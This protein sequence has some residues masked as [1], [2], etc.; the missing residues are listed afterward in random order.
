MQDGAFRT[1]TLGN[2]RSS[3][4]SKAAAAHLLLNATAAA[5]TANHV[6]YGSIA[7]ALGSAGQ[8]TYA[9][10]NGELESLAEQYAAKVSISTSK[11]SFFLFPR[12]WGDDYDYSL[13]SNDC[14]C[15]H[16]KYYSDNNGF[17]IKRP[18]ITIN[19][20]LV[21]FYRFIIKVIRFGFGKLVQSV[22]ASLSHFFYS[23]HGGFCVL[24]YT[25]FRKSLIIFCLKLKNSLKYIHLQGVSPIN[26]AW[27]AWDGVGMAAN[28]NAV[29]AKL[30]SVGISSMRPDGGLEIMQ[31]ILAARPVVA[32]TTLLVADI[33]WN[34]LL[35]NGRDH[36][37][38]YADLVVAKA[39]AAV[40]PIRR[41]TVVQQDYTAIVHSTLEHVLGHTV[42]ADEPLLA[43]GLDS[44]GTG[45]VHSK[46]EHSTGITLPSTLV[47]DYP[48]A[49]AIIALLLELQPHASTSPSKDED[50][51]GG[52]PLPIRRQRQSHEAVVSTISQ[53]V[54]KVLGNAHGVDVPLMSAGLDSLGV[55][56]LQKELA[57]AFAIEI[58]ATIAFDYPSISA[59]ATFIESNLEVEEDEAEEDVVVVPESSAAALVATTTNKICTAAPTLTKAGYFSVPSIKRLQRMSEEELKQVPRFVIGRQGYGE[60]AFLYPVDLRYANLDDIVQI[61]KGSITLYPTSSKPLPGDGLNQPAL[62]TFKKVFVRGKATKASVLAFKGVLLQ[63]C[64]RMAATFV[65]WDPDEGAWIAKVDAFS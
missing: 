65:H 2:V 61:R 57:D 45:E 23:L 40:D 62:L 5:P 48:T 32:A 33:E 53:R 37:Q 3:I 7:A 38:F 10:S 58:P 21:I 20:S 28:A 12:I 29:K 42:G 47:F 54:S 27:G 64:A 55:G 39:A 60:I 56:Q 1:Q 16:G 63:A 34:R 43:A 51:V 49:S 14:R 22:V 59:I 18:I 26:I 4:A 30:H 24:N 9:M 8:M 36:M 35:T 6:L 31:R 13:W 19:A 46:L 52:G 41:R 25:F 44:I 15:C 50:S 11:F 17:T